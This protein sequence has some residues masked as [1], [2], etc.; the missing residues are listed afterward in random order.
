MVGFYGKSG[1]L[2]H[3]LD[4]FGEGFN[5]DDPPSVR[6]PTWL[7]FDKACRQSAQLLGV[8]QAATAAASMADAVAEDGVFLPEFG[9]FQ[10]MKILLKRHVMLNNHHGTPFFGCEKVMS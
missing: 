8:C 9:G 7:P 2:Y 4:A 3:T 6:K 10:T 5:W 1:K